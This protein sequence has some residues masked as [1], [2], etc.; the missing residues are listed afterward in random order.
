A[1]GRRPPSG[2][3]HRRSRR[4]GPVPGGA[5]PSRRSRA[6]DRRRGRLP[7]RRCDRHTAPRARGGGPPD[8]SR[9]VQDAL[10]TELERLCPGGVRQHEPLARHVTFRIGGPAD[11][12]LLPR[13]LEHLAA[14]AAWLYREDHPFV[15]LGRGS[16]VLVA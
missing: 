9:V 16:N 12:L 1:G 4:G 11:V 7:D 10:V 5:P 3:V 14:A 15:I 13:S 8:V 6:D 2:G